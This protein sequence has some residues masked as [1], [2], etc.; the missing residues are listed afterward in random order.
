MLFRSVFG[1][2]AGTGAVGVW[3]SG[4]D[5]EEKDETIAAGVAPT[6]AAIRR[7]ATFI[8][9]GALNSRPGGPAVCV[10]VPAHP[11]QNIGMNDSRTVITINAQT[12]YCKINIERVQDQY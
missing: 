6:L 11:G 12:L 4:A 10:R 7:V 2:G 8:D 5:A 1:A 9:T 3:A